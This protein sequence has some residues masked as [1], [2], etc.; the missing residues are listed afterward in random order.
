M[1]LPRTFTDEHGVTHA[2]FPLDGVHGVVMACSRHLRV[3]EDWDKRARP[4]TCLI[5]R[6]RSR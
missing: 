3:S 6:A 2:Q 4:V 5:C 1:T